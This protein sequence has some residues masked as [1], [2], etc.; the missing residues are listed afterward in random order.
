MKIKR[1][2]SVEESFDLPLL[3]AQPFDVVGFGTNSVDHLCVLSEFPASDSKCEILHYEILAGGQVATAVTFLS[4]MGVRARYIAKV[5]GDELGRFSLESFRSE[6]VDTAGVQVDKSAA[7]Q[8]AIILI[9]Q[10]S[11]ER[12]VLTRRERGLDFKPGELKR[13][14]ICSGR[15]LHLDGYDIAG[16]ILAAEWCND[17]GIP[18]CIDLDKA[19]HHCQELLDKIDFL[20][21]SKNF[22]IEFTGLADPLKAFERLRNEFGGFLAMTMGA[23]GAMA[24]VG[25]QCVTF[26]A[27]KV[28]AVDSTGAG[29]IFHGG[30]IYGLLQNWPLQRIMNFANAAAGLSCGYLGARTGI[31]PLSEILQKLP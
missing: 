26:P 17:A 10:K 15:I 27:I 1:L 4:R 13:E 14:Q 31:R 22:P 18:V 30:F 21:V 5:G 8:A 25:D 28:D 24:W 3:D 12:T 16:S 29:D 20:I 2:I 6:S 23:A 9:E 7:N 19:F 11:G